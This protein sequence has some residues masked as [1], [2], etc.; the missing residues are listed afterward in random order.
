MDEILPFKYSH[1]VCLTERFHSCMDVKR[2]NVSPNLK[3]GLDF[4]WVLL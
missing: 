4:L 3:K 1:S 2:I